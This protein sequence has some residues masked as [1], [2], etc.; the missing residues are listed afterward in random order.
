VPAEAKQLLQRLGLGHGA[1]EAE[2]VLLGV[3]IDKV[4][5]PVQ[6]LVG[7]N[8]WLIASNPEEFLGQLFDN[9]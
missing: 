4:K 7:A 6:N 2:L 8:G 5:R 3:G 9:A 1:V